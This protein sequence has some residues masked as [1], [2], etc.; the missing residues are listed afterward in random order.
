[1][2]ARTNVGNLAK[3]QAFVPPFSTHFADY[4]KTRMY[5]KSYCQ[6][7]PFGWLQTGVEDFDRL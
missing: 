3:C 4:D 6:C 7:D 2:D 5:P 1:L